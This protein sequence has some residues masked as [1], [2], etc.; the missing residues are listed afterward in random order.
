MADELREIQDEFIRD[1]DAEHGYLRMGFLAA[2][3]INVAANW[4]RD[5]M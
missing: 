1:R 3:A 2:K 4:K 5:L